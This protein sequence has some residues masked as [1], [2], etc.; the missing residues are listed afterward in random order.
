MN[1]RPMKAKNLNFTCSFELASQCY[2]QWASVLIVFG[3]LYR[4][5][6]I[7]TLLKGNPAKEQGVTYY[8][9]VSYL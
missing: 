7:D 9:C 5:I 1:L 4:F 8:L 3:P 2:W 6:D